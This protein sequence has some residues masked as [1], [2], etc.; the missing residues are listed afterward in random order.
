MSPSGEELSEDGREIAR[1]AGRE[2]GAVRRASQNNERE[3]TG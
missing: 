2:K 3:E 1:K